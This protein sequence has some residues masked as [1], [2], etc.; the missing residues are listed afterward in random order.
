MGLAETALVLFAVVFLR[1]GAA[2]AILPAFGERSVP[3]RIRLVLALGFTAIVAPAV[4]PT[5]GPVLEGSPG[6]LAL[7][8]GEI[9]VGLL[10][11]LAIRLFVLALQT[12]GAIAAQ[13][14]SLAQIF[15][16]VIVDPQPAMAHVMIIA[17]LAIAVI[18]GLHVKVVEFLVLSYRLFPAGDLP[19]A[20]DLMR[21][22]VGHVAQMFG[23]AFTLAAPF[24]IVSLLYNLSLGVINRAMPQL[25]VALVGAP[26][27]TLGA[28]VLLAIALPFL[29]AT[30]VAAMDGF[31][32]DP[33][34]AF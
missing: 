34:G 21:W 24:V 33:F 16:N 26:A 9:V 8:G 4:A 5:L 2:M 18:L 6:Y 19:G 23:L 17:G 10:L 32:A 1:V 20:D 30:W 11:G 28:L 3:E 15:G 14:T 29:L 27:I 12:A 7:L 22:G 31:F 13:S 25:M